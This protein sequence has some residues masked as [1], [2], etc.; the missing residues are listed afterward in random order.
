M[1]G[2][3][4]GNKCGGAFNGVAHRS[5]HSL[6]QFT[7]RRLSKKKDKKSNDPYYDNVSFWLRMEGAIG[8]SVFTDNSKNNL[9]VISYGST[10]TSSAS[11][12]NWGT[13]ATFN[14]SARME[15]QNVGEALYF[16]TSNF[17]IE[18]WSYRT[19]GT[20]FCRFLFSPAWSLE[21]GST[22]SNVKWGVL[23]YGGYL[24]TNNGY[25]S[26][27]VW[28]HVAV[29]RNNGVTRYY[30]NGNVI[31]TVSDSRTYQNVNGSLWIG[32]YSDNSFPFYGY[33]DEIKVTQG[34]ARYTGDSFAPPS[35][36]FYFKDN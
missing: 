4:L 36:P 14:S 27:N 1:Q 20:A 10:I 21:Y 11:R 9:K 25:G 32:A 26:L 12:S 2:L 18:F 35:E 24:F 5:P 28:N 31:T 19:T 17:T 34:I 7:L 33:V 22:A 3:G 29:V 6:T 30:L 8:S 23:G 13:S 15:V 16:G